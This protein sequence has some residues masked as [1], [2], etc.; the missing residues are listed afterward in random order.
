M[1]KDPLTPETLKNRILSELYHSDEDVLFFTSRINPQI[2]EFNISI[3]SELTIHLW[4]VY[5]DPEDSS[6]HY[7]IVFEEEENIF[8]L[9]H[10]TENGNYFIGY[11]GSFLDALHSM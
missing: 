8:G 10:C 5:V 11:Y 6:F 1:T 7:A 3:D 2:E 4:N 9:A